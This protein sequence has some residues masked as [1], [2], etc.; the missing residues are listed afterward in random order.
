L[1][2][3]GAASNSETGQ[4]ASSD[5]DT[6]LEAVWPKAATSLERTG[7]HGGDGAWSVTLKHQLEA[8]LLKQLRFYDM[9]AMR[10]IDMKVFLA[11]GGS[12][13][14]TVSS[15][16]KHPDGNQCLVHPP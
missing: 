13:W 4:P 15:N 6:A 10:G 1:L 7:D 2:Q 8:P 12:S 14:R 5:P 11:T 16:S 3:Q 9:F